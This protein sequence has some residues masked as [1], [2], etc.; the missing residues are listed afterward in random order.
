MEEIHR[1]LN[2]DKKFIEQNKI[3]EENK[4]DDRKSSN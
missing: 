4:N 2:I 3:D 1:D